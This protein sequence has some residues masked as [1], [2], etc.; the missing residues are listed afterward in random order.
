MAVLPFQRLAGFRAAEIVNAR[1]GMGVDD[2]KRTGLAVQMR[3]HAAQHG[4]LHDIGE[5]AGVIGVT[6]VHC[7]R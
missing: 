2:A 5:V 6:I 7:G 3:E 4:V 1:A